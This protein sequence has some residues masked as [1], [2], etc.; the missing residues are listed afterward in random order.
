MSSDLNRRAWLLAAGAAWLGAGSIDRL[1]AQPS[2]G[3]K[4]VLF[5]TKSSGFPHS[6]IT[7]E[8]EKLGMAERILTDLGKEH[9][10]DVVAS[11][12]GRLF[13]PDQIG[14]WDAFVFETT[15]DL[16]TEGGDKNP[17]ISADGEKAFYDPQWQRLHGNAL[18]N[19]YVRASR[20]TEQRRRRSLYP[21]DRC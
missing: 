4:K 17:P 10:F 20:K 18:C 13:E 9:G 1:L 14:Q 5:F 19:R 2:G 7:R 16:T 6:V 11:K 12:D 3:R 21:D 8:G 15:G